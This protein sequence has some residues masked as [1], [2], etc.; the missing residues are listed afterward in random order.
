MFAQIFT[1]LPLLALV[2]AA[3]VE[4]KM[5]K[6]IDHSGTATY[7]ETGLGACGWVS[8]GYPVPSHTS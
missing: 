8:F 4:N 5:E 7:Y 3:P 6:R 1:L 2:A